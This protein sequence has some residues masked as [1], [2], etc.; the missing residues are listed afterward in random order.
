VKTI[1]ITAELTYDDDMMHT[2][3]KDK[4]AK[5]WFVNEI[6]LGETLRVYSNEI[7]D[8]VG[9]MKIIKISKRTP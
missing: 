2:G 4:Q 7:C 1:R 6:L 5:E 3:Y 9:E 8:E